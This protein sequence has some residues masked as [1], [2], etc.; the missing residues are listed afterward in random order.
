MAA[1]VPA[2]LSA[3]EGRKFGLTV[4][5]AVLVLA[6]VAWWRG[7]ARTAPLLGSLG[8]LLLLAALALPTRLGPVIRGWMALAQAISRVTTPILL[9]IVYFVVITPVGLMLRALG[10]DP[11]P[12]PRSGQS[13]W[14][15]KAATKSDLERQF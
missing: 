14:L 13:G 5:S 3:P 10:R 12:R 7:H 15:D 2:R 6:G 4:G 1:G 8:V 11:L 9:A